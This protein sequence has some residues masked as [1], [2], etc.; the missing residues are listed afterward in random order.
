VVSA[1]EVDASPS[2]SPT[3]DA[4]G[5]TDATESAA[6][7]A[8]GF[9]ES[10]TDAAAVAATVPQPL[11]GSFP[12]TSAATG[13]GDNCDNGATGEGASADPLS[14]SVP[15]GLP[16]DEGLSSASGDGANSAFAADDNGTDPLA[17]LAAPSSAAPVESDGL[18][19][20]DYAVSGPEGSA[21]TAAVAAT[22]D[23]TV[24]A[25]PPP[26]TDDEFA[27][28]VNSSNIDASAINEASDEGTAVSAT[29][30]DAFIQ[31]D[32]EMGDEI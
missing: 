26:P 30:D 15:D 12:M 10:E 9:A 3:A 6:T 22:D 1:N 16:A 17:S 4:A 13:G 2:S 14:L 27:V 28:H 18:M 20:Q 31:Q 23:A 29:D 5:A 21:D 11:L 8:N 7:A 19:H 32:D 25:A 24:M